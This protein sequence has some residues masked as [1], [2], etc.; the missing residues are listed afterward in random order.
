MCQY[1]S[2][3]D[4]LALIYSIASECPSFYPIA[5][6]TTLLEAAKVEDWPA[7]SRLRPHPPFNKQWSLRKATLAHLSIDPY[8]RRANN[9]ASSGFGTYKATVSVEAVI[10]PTKVTLAQDFHLPPIFCFELWT[11]RTW[12]SPKFQHWKCRNWAAEI[13]LKRT[14]D[15]GDYWYH[16]WEPVLH[17]LSYSVTTC[18]V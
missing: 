6:V 12:S 17:V 18:Y 3:I 10:N 1:C 13:V 14:L 8:E 11:L 7:R 15:E 2:N 4:L 9:S 5:L 16:Y